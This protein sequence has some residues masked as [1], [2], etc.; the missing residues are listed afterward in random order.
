[1]NSIFKKNISE[2]IKES[3]YGIYQKSKSG[4]I[5]LTVEDIY[6]KINKNTFGKSGMNIEELCE[7][8]GISKSE[9]NKA[10]LEGIK[11]P[12]IDSLA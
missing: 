6:K 1:M 3:A 4:G 5:E 2:K 11:A 9:I 8:S 12:S 10:I 7:R